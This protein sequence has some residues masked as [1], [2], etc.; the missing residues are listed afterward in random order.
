MQSIR[1]EYPQPQFKRDGYWKNLNG[2]WNFKFDDLD[3]GKREG[4]G[5][6]LPEPQKIIVPFV[7]QSPASGIN[8][9][10]RHDIVWYENQFETRHLSSDEHLIVH[11]GAVDYFADVYVNGEYI[12]HHEGGDCSFSFD[13]TDSLNTNQ[14]Q[15]ITVRAEDLTFDE[16]IPRGKQ[17][18][19]GRSEGIWYTNSTGIWQTVWLE[20]INDKCIHNI[21]LTPDLDKTSVQINAQLSDQ[22][23]GSRLHY[24][25]IFNGEIVVDDLLIVQTTNIIR[26]VELMQQHIFRTEF[27]HAGWTWTPEHP[28]LFDV[29]FELVD[30]N[31]NCVDHVD[32]YFGLRKVSTEN[33]MIMLN[34]RPYYQRLV[35]DQGYWPDGLI[36]A[37]TDDALKADIELS[38][39]MG[40]NGCRKHQKIED[41][42][43]LYWADKLGFLVWEEVASVPYYS[44]K[45][46]ARLI[47]AWKEA[48]ERDYNHPSIIMWVPLNESWGVDRIHTSKQQ[49]H[50]SEALYHMI[51]ALDTTRLVQS[52]DGWDNT[53]TDVVAI[54]NYNHGITKE[55][56]E[57]QNYVDMLSNTE[58]LITQAPGAWDIFANGFTYQ[59]QPIVLSEFGGIG[60]DSSR[61]DGWGYTTAN[62]ETEYLSELHRIIEAVAASKGLWGYCYT[63]LT[64]VEQEVNGLLT[65]SREPKADLKEINKI[66][67]M[68]SDLRLANNY[69]KY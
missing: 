55:S 37:P 60:F 1:E 19:T 29:E 5:Q 54:H 65:Y 38:K 69:K 59:G 67:T 24:K 8:N 22:A 52:N 23:L 18:W 35:L 62:N 40:F 50:F 34:N 51:H 16:T 12:G 27:H 20:V 45:S 39:E 44:E 7:Y 68:T 14:M 28:N 11:F 9:Q 42:R 10:S 3:L 63:Q 57:Y 21:K 43:F 17:S 31:D 49:Q 4:W 36:T 13:V 61:E 25:I 41:P 33:G 26:S 58:K 32:T 53:V 48:I 47:D 64:D 56:K 46:A 15:K 66:F 30:E 2:E 6:S